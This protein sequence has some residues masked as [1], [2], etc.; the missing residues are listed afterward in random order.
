M[1]GRRLG[2]FLILLM[3]MAGPVIAQESGS[4]VLLR[5]QEELFDKRFLVTEPLEEF[6]LLLPKTESTGTITL[7]RP[8]G[9]KIYSQRRPDDVR[10]RVGKLIDAVQLK[11]MEPGPWQIHM[12]LPPNQ[13]LYLLRD[14]YLDAEPLPDQVFRGDQLDLVSW[15]ATPEGRLNAPLVGLSLATVRIAEGRKGRAP[16]FLIA[17][18]PDIE[19]TPAVDDS[20]I[21]FSLPV[22]MA[23][24]IY[25]LRL[26]LEFGIFGRDLVR[27]FE[28]LPSPFSYTFKRAPSYLEPHRVEVDMNQTPQMQMTDVRLEGYFTLP[29]GERTEVRVS[30]GRY[31]P[32]RILIPSMPEGGIYQLKLVAKGKDAAGEPME[33]KLDNF[34]FATPPDPLW[35][36]QKQALEAREKS[37]QQAASA[38]KAV[39]PA[40]PAK[41]YAALW[42]VMG[43][44]TLLMAGGIGGFTWHRR[45]KKPQDE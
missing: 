37:L 29:S 43:T 36:A 14:F 28:V 27:R 16:L 42:W 3:T 22:T 4:L 30:P 21:E 8:D 38:A 13:P 25:D 44:N 40:K 17:S 24:G 15:I 41:S 45:R 2:A 11:Q 23:P 12:D 1:K 32:K 5:D 10:W 35:L 39:Q 26:H 31:W 7:V 33:L 6:Y 9:T 19:K 34:R 20:Q 18:V